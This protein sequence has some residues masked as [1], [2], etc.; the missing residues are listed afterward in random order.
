MY[1]VTCVL[2]PSLTWAGGLLGLS[3]D[4]A[5]LSPARVQGAVR[6]RALSPQDP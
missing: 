3:C 1:F 5:A 4:T 6:L 2:V